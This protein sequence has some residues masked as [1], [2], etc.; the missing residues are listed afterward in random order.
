[1]E[2]HSF[3][4]S[5]EKSKINSANDKNQLKCDCFS[6]GMFNSVWERFW[7]NSASGKPLGEK[8]TILAKNTF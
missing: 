3:T 1:M 2:N 5:K 7:N 8:S 6:G 4:F